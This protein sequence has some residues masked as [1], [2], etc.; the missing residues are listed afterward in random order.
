MAGRYASVNDFVPN[1]I[2]ASDKGKDH[3]HYA[4]YDIGSAYAL[5][6]Q[7]HRALEWFRRAAADGVPCYPR[8]AHDPKLNGIRDDPEFRSFL[9]GLRR[10]WE[11]FN[12]AL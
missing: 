5:M 7:P 4:E 8:F 6:N 9:D 11:E 1:A 10:Q 3:F 2:M 12:A